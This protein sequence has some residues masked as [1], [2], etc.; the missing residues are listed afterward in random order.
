MEREGD[1]RIIKKIRGIRKGVF[2]ATD[3]IGIF[4]LIEGMKPDKRE[5]YQSGYLAAIGDVFDLADKKEDG[6]HQFR[7]KIVKDGKLLKTIGGGQIFSYNGAY[8]YITGAFM[9]ETGSKNTNMGKFRIWNDDAD[10][11]FGIYVDFA[12]VP[13]LAQFLEMDFERS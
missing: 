12:D 8:Y 13:G 9:A 4:H 1:G 11:F 2:M 3:K 5:G 10:S 7:K 6:F